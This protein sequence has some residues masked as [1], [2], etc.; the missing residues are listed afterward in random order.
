MVQQRVA[1]Q[2]EAGPEDPWIFDF[3][4]LI[5]RNGLVEILV[6]FVENV[7]CVALIEGIDDVVVDL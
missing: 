3:L 1:E 5:A 6:H 7:V 2:D 4:T